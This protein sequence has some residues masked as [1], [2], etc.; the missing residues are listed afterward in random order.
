MSR[1]K[2]SFGSLVVGAVLAVLSETSAQA[3]ELLNNG[4]FETGNFAGWTTTTNGV[5]ELTPWQV[6]GPGHGWFANSHPLAGQY[7][8]LNGFDGGAGLVYNLYQDVTIPSLNQA[9]LTANDRIEYNSLG[10]PSTLDRVFEI[11]VKDTSGNVLQ[12]LYS[13][14]VTINGAGMTDLGWVSHT[15]D[16]SSYAGS[17]VRID[18]REFIPET[19]TGPA[20]IEFDNLSLQATPSNT[21]PEPATLIIWSLLGGLAITAGWRRRRKSA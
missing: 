10:I 16:L 13:L 17:T 5:S 15:F 4:G 20:N 12:T 3:V 7:D 6:V 19:F 1:W 21:V 8:A 9:I 11:N 2:A 14:S 18:F